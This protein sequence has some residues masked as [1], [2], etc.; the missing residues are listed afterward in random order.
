MR[1]AV[2]Q[3]LLQYQGIFVINMARLSVEPESGITVFLSTLDPVPYGFRRGLRDAIG[4]ARGEIVLG[5]L[6]EGEGDDSVRIFIM[7]DAPSEPAPAATES[8]REAP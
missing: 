1:K 5:E 6:I 2:A 7:T 4:I 8:G 3:Y